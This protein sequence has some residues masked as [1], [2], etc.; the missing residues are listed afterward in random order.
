VQQRC[1]W[2]NEIVYLQTLKLICKQML[3]EYKVKAKPLIP[4]H[5]MARDIA[6]YFS[7]F[8]IHHNGREGYHVEAKQMCSSLVFNFPMQTL[9]IESYDQV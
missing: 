4:L 7:I 2:V 5:L 1:T 3:G 8:H 9:V 6:K